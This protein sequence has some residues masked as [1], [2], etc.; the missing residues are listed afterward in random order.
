M[1]EQ[2]LKRLIVDADQSEFSSP[3]SLSGDTIQQLARRQLRR[4]TVC[5]VALTSVVTLAAIAKAPWQRDVAQ[6]ESLSESVADR[7]A[8]ENEGV[9]MTESVDELLARSAQLRQR[10]SAE[11][12]I[13]RRV[14]LQRQSRSDIDDISIV[15]LAM[16]DYLSHSGST[17]SARSELMRIRDRFP[18]SFAA[19]LAAERLAKLHSESK[20]HNTGNEETKN[21]DA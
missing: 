10:I 5:L 18:N 9:D 2:K 19:P 7:R 14:R 6:R 17:E 3:A 13:A 1:D 12:R 16:A 21:A 15:N 4:R 11:L 8:D 20:D